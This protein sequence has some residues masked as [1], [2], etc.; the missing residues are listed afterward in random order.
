MR[1]YELQT[2]R[3]IRKQE[4]EGRRLE[5]GASSSR[6]VPKVLLCCLSGKQERFGAPGLFGSHLK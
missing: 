5:T 2:N 6:S 3:A 4:A 1:R